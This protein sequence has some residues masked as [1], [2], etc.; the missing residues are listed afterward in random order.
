M[1]SACPRCNY[2]LRGLPADHQCPECGLK[3]DAESEAFRIP[4]RRWRTIGECCWALFGV[5]YFPWIVWRT[6]NALGVLFTV[7]MILLFSIFAASLLWLR[8]RAHLR[9]GYVVAVLPEGVFFRHLRERMFAYSDFVTVLSRP[10]LR[11]AVLAKLP[12]ELLVNVS[13][14]GRIIGDVFDSADS[15]RRFASLVEQRLA[16]RRSEALA[17][18]NE[19]VKPPVEE[20]SNI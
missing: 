14:A 13:S 1:L 10:R 6:G 2:D 17:S 19:G 20:P 9:G 4:R 3:Y 12:D 8:R 7:L 11:H 18:Q 16:A 5:T 15:V